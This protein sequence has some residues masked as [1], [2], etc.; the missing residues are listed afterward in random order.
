MKRR[1]EEKQEFKLHYSDSSEQYPIIIDSDDELTIHPTKTTDTLKN[2]NEISFTG[3][4]LTYRLNNLK[5]YSGSPNVG[6]IKLSDIIQSN[7]KSAIMTTYQLDIDWLLYNFPIL[8]EIP[9]MIVHGQSELFY[10]CE[11]PLSF[12]IKKAHLPLAYGCCHGKIMI[13]KYPDFIRVVVSTA[14]LLSIDYDR[15]TQGLWVQDFPKL[16]QPAEP[17]SPLAIDFKSTLEDYLISLG[18][19]TNFLVEYSFEDVRV[20][21]VTSVPGYHKGEKLFSYGHMKIRKWLSNEVKSQM[22]KSTLIA[23]FSSMGSLSKNWLEEFIESLIPSSSISKE[24]KKIDKK[25]KK[26]FLMIM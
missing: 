5:S 3:P 6:V 13:L 1:E 26:K 12:H 11:L 4:Q 17:I 21:L 7:I 15:K 18:L 9:V 25:P 19:K 8:K 16:N 10:K 2:S 24:T 22:D 23:Q 20:V 14:N